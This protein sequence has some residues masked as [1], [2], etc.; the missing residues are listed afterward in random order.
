MAK[1]TDVTTTLLFDMKNKAREQF[2]YSN[3]NE[4]FDGRNVVLSLKGG[5]TLGGEIRYF[6]DDV[7]VLVAEPKSAL[8]IETKIV[9]TIV[10]KEKVEF[11]QFKTDK[12]KD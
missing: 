9:H 2:D 5:T 3:L 12:Q 11:I 10:Y 1:K 6:D 4:L 8:D 7:L